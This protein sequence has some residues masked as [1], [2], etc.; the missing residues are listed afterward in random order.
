MRISSKQLRQIIREELLREGNEGSLADYTIKTKDGALEVTHKSGASGVSK[1][2]QV[3]AYGKIIDVI[4]VS[5]KSF[6]PFA[7]PDQP[8]FVANVELDTVGPNITKEAALKNRVALLGI[9]NAIING[10][11][12]KAP[13]GPLPGGGSASLII[14]ATG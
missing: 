2:I 7:P 6:N 1:K 13:P 8:V 3:E 10:T 14:N 5:L 9:A 12:Y 4:G 11:Y